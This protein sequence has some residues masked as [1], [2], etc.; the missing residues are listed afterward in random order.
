LQ[1]GASGARADDTKSLKSAIID[2]LSPP[3]EPLRPSIARN[4]KVDRGF[5]HE[6]T[7]ALLCPAGLDWSD[8]GSTVLSF[9]F[10]N[11]FDAFF[12]NRIREKLR[13]GELSVS[14]DQWPIFIYKDYQFHENDPWRG[15]L[16]SLIL[17]KVCLACIVYSNI[18][19]L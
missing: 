15:L 18:P 5:N 11:Q 8:L 6:A 7:G 9:L 19:Q 4:I 10:S 12:S 17:V 14:G 13:T 16:R 1:K 2:W 3:G